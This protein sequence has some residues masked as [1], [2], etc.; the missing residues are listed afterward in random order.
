[1]AVRFAFELID[2][3]TGPASK[4]GKATAGLSAGFGAAGKQVDKIVGG[5]RISKGL[6]RIQGG[7]ELAFGKNA[8]QTFGRFATGQLT[9]ADKIGLVRKG[10]ELQVGALKAVGSGLMAVGNIALTTTAA[11]MGLVSAAG[12][13]ALAGGKQ[14]LEAQRYRDATGAALKFQLGSA[15]EAQKT[16]GFLANIARVTGQDRREATAQFSELVGSG[17]TTPESQMLVQLAADLKV[18]SGGK[19]VGVGK[20]GDALLSLKR[21]EALSV[22]KSFAGLLAAGGQNRVYEALAKRLNIKS[23]GLDPVAIKRLVD[24]RLAGANGGM[25]LRGQAAV[26]MFRDINMDVAGESAFGGLQKSFQATTVT[27]AIDLVHQRL[28]ALFDDTDASPIAQ[29][30]LGLLNQLATALDPTSESGKQLLATFDMLVSGAARL[31]DFIKPLAEALGGGFAQGFGEAADTVSE[32]IGILDD[33][34]GSATNFGD[35]LRM[36]GTALGYVVVGI[37]AGIAAIAA[38]EAKL[39]GIATALVGA[40]ASIGVAIIEGMIGGVESA[41][42]RLIARL[43]ALAALLPQSVRKLLGIKSPSRVMMQLGAY[44]AEGF[45]LGVERGAPDVAQ[46]AKDGMTSPVVRV[47]AKAGG[48][49]ARGTATFAPGAIVVN[50]QGAKDGID[51]ERAVQEGIRRA[52]VEMGMELGTT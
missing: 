21:N 36:I 44:T 33:G 51:I 20:L 40:A 3:F 14:L 1:M 42:A 32:I 27:G 26:D 37:G 5:D 34:S 19:D 4:I 17:L 39:A 35:A 15:E 12:G 31:W 11:M 23:A 43:E 10:A 29:R 24:Q 7:V 13:L 30:L 6:R 18:A 8:A 48:G 50:A 47:D 22:E 16:M 41:K 49:A 2:R 38:I 45:A 25:G 52:L 9:M 46:A 28:K